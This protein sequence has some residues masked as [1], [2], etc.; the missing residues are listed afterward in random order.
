M[1]NKI[2]NIINNTNPKKVSQEI[3]KDEDLYQTINQYFGST[4]AE[5]V[6]N[7]LNPNQN[8]CKNNKFKKFNS[9]SNG[10][11]FCGKASVCECARECVSKAVS[12]TKQMYSEQKKKQINQKRSNTNIKK[13]GVSNVG[14]TP[15]AKKSHF[16]FYQDSKNIETVNK[17]VQKT[18]LLKYGDKNYN[19]SVKIKQSLKEKFDTD[20]W[21]ERLENRNIEILHNEQKMKELFEKYSVTEI[22]DQL[23]VHIQTVYRYLNLYKIKTPFESS[24][25]KEIVDFLRSIGINNIVRNTRKLLPTRKEIDIYLPDYN[26]A[27]EYN[28]VYWHHEDI[29]HITRSYHQSKYKQC[30]DLGIQLITIFSNF[31]KSKPDIVKNILINRL[32][33]NKEK[34]YARK[35][36]IK[37]IKS[38][39][40][41][42]FLEKYHIQGYT[43]ASVCLGLYYKDD[44]KAVMTFSKSRI[45]IGKNKN[46]NELVR[47]ASKTRVVGGAS[48]LLKY[49][50]QN[51]SQDE[52]YSYSNNEWSNGKLYNS[53]GFELVKEISPSYWYLKPREE[54]L[55]HR[56]NFAKQKLVAQGYDPALTEKQITHQIGLLK[57]WDCGK[58]LWI[59]NKKS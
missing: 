45:A 15:V 8:I 58:K 56:F 1:K 48:K 50:V 59:Y 49:F 22:A 39:D 4:I 2:L 40:I 46:G 11:K 36:S 20:Y 14:Q 16:D 37:E 29:D 19:N 34:I 24:E 21:I 9:I 44:L 38:K 35:C 55:V 23:E 26:L 3:K 57:V 6:Y 31:W 43:P 28:G 32:G 54:K 42:T 7:Y 25:E 17:K 12:N 41:K 10:Y 52:I 13:Y 33:I 27:I 5:K 30:Q 18:K 51:Y 53:L 47:F